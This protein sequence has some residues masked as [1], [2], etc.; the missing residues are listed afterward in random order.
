[1]H[2]G[3]RLGL[4]AVPEPPTLEQQPVRGEAQHACQLPSW[5]V[6]QQE[7]GSAGGGLYPVWCKWQPGTVWL[8]VWWGCLALAAARQMLLVV[9]RRLQ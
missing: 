5:P 2:G 3:H 9:A 8:D 7:A 6:L 1:V 4:V